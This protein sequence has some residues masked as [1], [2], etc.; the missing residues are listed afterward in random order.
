M[1]ALEVIHRASIYTLLL[2]VLPAACGYTSGFDLASGG[3]RKIAVQIAGNQTFR[4]RLE[5]PLTHELVRQLPIRT[6]LIITSHSNADAILEVSINDVLDR[7]LVIGST[8]VLEGGLIF[9][10]KMRLVDQKTGSVLR[11]RTI[12]DRAEFRVPIGENAVSATSE[13]AHDLARKVLLALE[14]DF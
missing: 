7:T 1:R 4:Q 6:G 2:A 12:M 10:V 9:A 14:S 5:I 8:P 13:A 3:T 11:E